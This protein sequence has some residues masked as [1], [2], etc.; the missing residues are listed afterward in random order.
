MHV[1]KQLAAIAYQREKEKKLKWN[2][3]EVKSNAQEY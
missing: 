1:I 3:Q 2:K